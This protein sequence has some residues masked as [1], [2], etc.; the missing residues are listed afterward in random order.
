VTHSLDCRQPA[1]AI[2]SA[3][4]QKPA[5][6]LRGVD[7]CGIVISAARH[8]VDALALVADVAFDDALAELEVALNGDSIKAEA[9][10]ILRSHIDRVML[11]S[12]AYAPNGLRVGSLW[13]PV[14]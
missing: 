2:A 12:A 4:V 6:T 9:G 10:E 3:S 14:G 11:T 7:H 5:L 1:A 8:M 13:R